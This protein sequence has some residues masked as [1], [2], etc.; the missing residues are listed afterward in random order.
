MF[1]PGMRA[2]ERFHRRLSHLKR[3][4]SLFCRNSG[5][6]TG[7]HFRWNCSNGARFALS[8]E[9]LQ[10]TQD[11]CAL[12]EQVWADPFRRAV[13]LLRLPAGPVEHIAAPA[14][15]SFPP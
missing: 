3:S 7:S 11:G 12:P 1:R 15:R 4:I 14:S 13:T 9:L 8:P 2:L 10:A 5:R 6:E